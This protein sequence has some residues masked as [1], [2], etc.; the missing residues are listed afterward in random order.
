MIRLAAVGL[1]LA[2]LGGVWLW[3]DYGAPLLKR[4]QRSPPSRESGGT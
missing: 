1:F 3:T 2:F 4:V